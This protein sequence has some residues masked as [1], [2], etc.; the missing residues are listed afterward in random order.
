MDEWRRC[1][2]STFCSYFFL[3]RI[4][5]ELRMMPIEQ[6]N[7]YWWPMK[8]FRC[9]SIIFRHTVYKMKTKLKVNH[10]ARWAIFMSIVWLR[11]F[12][13]WENPN[14][15]IT[16]KFSRHRILICTSSVSAC[17]NQ[18]NCNKIPIKLIK[19]LFYQHLHCILKKSVA[20]HRWLIIIINCGRWIW[21]FGLKQLSIW[22]I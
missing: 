20:I 3:A 13:R 11:T 22:R 8:P 9:K 12:F 19:S 4:V 21:S 2:V 5:H 7:G 6:T 10:V 15:T 1:D 17:T 18:F 14:E 16:Q